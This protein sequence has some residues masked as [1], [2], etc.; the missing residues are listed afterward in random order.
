MEQAEYRI[1]PLTLQ[2][3]GTKSLA[4]GVCYSLIY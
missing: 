4:Y 1:T 3:S 2:G